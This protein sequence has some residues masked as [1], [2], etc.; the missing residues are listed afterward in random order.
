MK[1]KKKKR[2]EEVNILREGKIEA[3]LQH[4]RQMRGDSRFEAR[5]T[6]G[7]IVGWE[8]AN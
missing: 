3:N 5:I 6:E 4:E 8:W 7:E 1:E 2:D